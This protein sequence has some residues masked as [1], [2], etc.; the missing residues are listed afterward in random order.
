MVIGLNGRIPL[1]TAGNL[2]RQQLRATATTPRRPHLGNSVS[3]IDPTYALQNALQSERYNR[4]RYDYYDT[5]GRLHP[6]AQVGVHYQA[7]RSTTRQQLPGRQRRHRRP[8]DPAPQ[9]RLA[10][11][12]QL[13]QPAGRDTQTNGDPNYVPSTA[14]TNF[15]DVNGLR[16]R[17]SMPNGDRRLQRSTITTDANTRQSLRHATQRAG[18]RP[19]GRGQSIPG[20]P[21]TESQ[22]PRDSA[23]RQRRHVST[24]NN[25]VRAGYSSRYRRHP[26]RQ[27]RDAADDNY[28]SFD[29]YPPYDPSR[30]ARSGEVD[31][32]DLYDA[33]G[34]LLLPVERMRRWVTPADINGTGSVRHVERPPAQRRAPTTAPTP[35]AA[36]SST[37]T[38]GR[39][40]APGVDQRQL[41]RSPTARRYHHAARHRH[42]LGAIYYPAIDRPRSSTAAGPNPSRQC[43]AST[44]ARRL[45]PTCPT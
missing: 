8:P 13:R 16:P 1:N 28:N 41:H 25:P 9:P 26:Q 24:Y 15:V 11:L 44:A 12:T 14:T 42:D 29:P 37:A 20:I 31:D 19:L 34:A 22:R 39:P 36:S 18:R 43:T 30:G 35:S 38:S 33:A 3:E 5:Y 40:A 23:N 17:Y 6:L 32:T 10:G 21:F 4:G 27:P 2:R 45:P 7:R